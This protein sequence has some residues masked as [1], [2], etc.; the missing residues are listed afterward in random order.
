M[1]GEGGGND[2]DSAA[3]SSPVKGSSAKDATNPL[4]TV[5]SPPPPKSDQAIMQALQKS[6]VFQSNAQSAK[7]SSPASSDAG[8]NTPTTNPSGKKTRRTNSIYVTHFTD[9]IHSRSYAEANNA[10]NYL[11]ANTGSSKRKLKK[12][13]DGTVILSGANLRKL[14]MMKP[15]LSEYLHMEIMNMKV[16]D[17]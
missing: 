5:G 3:P 9:N 15:E 4:I 14:L 17:D 2:E 8:G 11:S 7:Q 12:A 13:V 10:D 1:V 6:L 16:M